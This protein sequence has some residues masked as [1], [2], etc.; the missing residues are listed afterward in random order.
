MEKPNREPMLMRDAKSSLIDEI[1]VGIALIAVGMCLAV[2]AYWHMFNP[3]MLLVALLFMIIGSFIYF[4]SKA[5]AI[6]TYHEMSKAFF[7]EK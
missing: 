4:K 2:H 3:Q 6:E 7:P 5:K 1:S